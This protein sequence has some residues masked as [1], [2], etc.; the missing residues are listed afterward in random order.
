MFYRNIEKWLDRKMKK[1]GSKIRIAPDDFGGLSGMQKIWRNF[2]D[3]QIRQF[4]FWK[5]R[6]VRILCETG[7]IS[8]TGRR[9]SLEAEMIKEKFKVSTAILSRLIANRLLR[10]EPR[11][12]GFYYEL[13]HDNLVKPIKRSAKN[14][15][16]VEG[17][18]GL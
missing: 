1:P 13:S 11:L 4:I 12:N 6:A 17:F 3:T 16:I 14:R 7:L 9:L 10:V 2:Y 18:T 15:K 8:S 5:R